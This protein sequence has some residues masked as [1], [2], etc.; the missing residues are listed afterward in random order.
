MVNASERFTERLRPHQVAAG[1]QVADLRIPELLAGTGV[2][3]V[4]GWVTGI[5]A[6]PRTVRIDDERVLEYDTL[7]YALGSVARRPS[8]GR[9]TTPTPLDGAHAAGLAGS[10]GGTVAVCGSGLTGV[11]AASEIAETHPELD[12]VLLGR[13]EPGARFTP[14]AKAHLDTALE[15]LGVRVRGGVEVVTV[16]EGSV[17]LAGGGGVAA[18]AVL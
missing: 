10:G 2:E 14:K 11:E 7:V 8:P 13:D 9:T 6:A 5:D 4:C 18:D 16:A 3:F 15:R 17:G 1:Q 12:V